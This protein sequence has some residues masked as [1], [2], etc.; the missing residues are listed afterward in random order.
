MTWLKTRYW[1]HVP[2]STARSRCTLSLVARSFEG[3]QGDVERVCLLERLLH[4][5]AG[6]VN[7]VL[8]LDDGNGDVGLVVEDVVGEFGL[9]ADDHLAA[10]VDLALGE[11]DVV[12]DLAQIAIS[13]V[14]GV[15]S[16]GSHH[17]LRAHNGLIRRPKHLRGTRIIDPAY[18]P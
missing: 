8:G 4:I 10:D 7:V 18:S 14:W 1:V 3:K 2:E 9:P 5:V 11:V 15:I 16:G 6:G 13:S 12:L 17:G